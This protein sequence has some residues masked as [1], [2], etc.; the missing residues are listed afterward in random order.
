MRQEFLRFSGAALA[1]AVIALNDD[2]TERLLLVGALILVGVVHRVIATRSIREQTISDIRGAAEQNLTE[3]SDP[4]G[5]S[6]PR[7]PAP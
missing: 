4:S 6:S 1:M 3:P 7:P 2:R 5:A